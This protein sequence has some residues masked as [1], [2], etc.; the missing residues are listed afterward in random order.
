LGDR[1]EARPLESLH[2]LSPEGSV[3]VEVE[4]LKAQRELDDAGARSK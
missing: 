4:E 3:S 1:K 2:H